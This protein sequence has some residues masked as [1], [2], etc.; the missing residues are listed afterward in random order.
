MLDAGCGMRGRHGVHDAASTLHVSQ[1]GNAATDPSSSSF[2][3]PVRRSLDEGG[4]SSVC[5]FEDDDEENEDE[6]PAE[7]RIFASSA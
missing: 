5:S 1:R 6:K 3:F 2:S 7:L 4:S